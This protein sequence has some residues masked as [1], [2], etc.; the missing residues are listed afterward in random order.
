[1]NT[2]KK[3]VQSEDFSL[4]SLMSCVKEVIEENA[5]LKSAMLL[6]PKQLPRAGL[7]GQIM[8]RVINS[9]DKLEEMM[10]QT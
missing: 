9:I 3:K 6:R 8:L 7:A 5:L 2:I 10:K 1:M 4:T